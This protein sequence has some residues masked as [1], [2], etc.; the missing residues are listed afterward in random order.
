M[1][2]DVIILHIRAPLNDNHIMY[3]LWDMEV[4]DRSF[5]HFGPFFAMLAP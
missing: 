4:T 1:P 3:G 2:G 5:C